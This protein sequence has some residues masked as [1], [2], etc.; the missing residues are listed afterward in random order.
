VLRGV[1]LVEVTR[2]AFVESVHAVAACVCSTEGLRR[3]E[4]ALGN[5]DAPVFLRSAAKPFIAAT[6]V[7]AGVVERFGLEPREIAVMSASHNGEPQHVEAVRSILHKSGFTEAALQCGPQAPQYGPAAAALAREGTEYSAIHNNCSGKHAGILALARSIGAD[8]TTYLEPQ[9]PAQVRILAFCGRMSDEDP[10]DFELAVDGCGIPVYAVPLRRAA[11]AYARFAT[12]ANL[13]D[14]D[15][16]ALAR[17][18]SALAAEPFY[19]AGTGRFDSNLIPASGGKV[20]GKAGAEGVHCDALLECRLG[21]ALK[22]IDGSRRAVPPAVL[23]LLHELDALDEREL[24]ALG[25]FAR[26][27]VLNFAGRVVGGIRAIARSQTPTA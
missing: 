4:L 25:T 9:N 13:A 11:L 19:L 1:P 6:A 22:V 8:P 3:P 17:V 14:E 27:Q 15:A 10:A 12:L 20:I 18:R 7:A 24:A 23:A 21:L 5:I 26:P 16:S 2:G